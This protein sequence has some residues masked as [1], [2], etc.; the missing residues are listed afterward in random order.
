MLA[1][2]A[3]HDS[4]PPTKFM[5]ATESGVNDDVTSRFPGSTV[6]YGSAASG[7]GDNREI[8]DEVCLYEYMVA[9]I[10]NW[11]SN[12]RAAASIPRPDVRPR[13]ATSKASEDP[14]ISCRH[15][16]THDLAIRIFRAMCETTRKRGQASTISDCYSIARSAV[17]QIR[18]EMSSASPETLVVEIR[19]LTHRWKLC[20][21]VLWFSYLRSLPVMICIHLQSR[22]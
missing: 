21:L 5:L 16:R 18:K 15:A 20:N 7:Q 12:R 3:V 13:H 1:C 14:R 4:E 2:C 9:Q 17:E 8:P 10:Q 22:E 19:M 6:T 11:H